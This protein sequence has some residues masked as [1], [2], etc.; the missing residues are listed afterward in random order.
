MNKE[1]NAPE[2]L[3]KARVLANEIIDT[4]E[5]AII[6]DHPEIGELIKGYEGHTLLHGIKYYE[7]EDWITQRIETG[8]FKVK[9]E[10]ELMKE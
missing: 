10:G 8:K 3:S 7:I 2:E 5:E 4:I 9:H 6:A 1:F